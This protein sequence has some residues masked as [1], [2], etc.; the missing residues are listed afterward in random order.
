MLGFDGEDEAGAVSAS[1]G[2]A[3]TVATVGGG[4]SGGA[5]DAMD[6][7]AGERGFPNAYILYYLF[8]FWLVVYR[9]LCVVFI[10]EMRRETYDSVVVFV[11][12]MDVDAGEPGFPNSYSRMFFSG[13]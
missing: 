6:V 5:G 13:L 7:D 10:P 2:G 11:V 12:P 8:C 9:M 4:E 3:A 1:A